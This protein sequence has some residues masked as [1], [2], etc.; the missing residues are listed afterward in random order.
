MS[1]CAASSCTCCRAALCASA[2]SDFSLTGGERSSFRFV[3][4][5]SSH[6]I[7]R[8]YLRFRCPRAPL[9]QHG[10]VRSAAEPCRLSSASPPHN[11]FSDLRLISAGALHESTSPASSLAP[12]S[13]RTLVLC[14]ALV[15]M[16][17]GGALQSLRCAILSA[18][19][20]ETQA[21]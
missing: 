14:L 13:A 17:F 2:T 21:L 19:R 6:S 5:C 11:S 7:R 20:Y 15:S 1:S 10:T 9:A 16:Q 3:S 18:T 12:A 4:G 8:Q